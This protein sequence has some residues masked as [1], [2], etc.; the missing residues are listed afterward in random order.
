MA[1]RKGD[2][3][4]YMDSQDNSLR[5]GSCET[6][7]APFHEANRRAV[8][9]LPHATRYRIGPTTRVPLSSVTPACELL[10]LA[11][12]PHSFLIGLRPF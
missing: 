10:F 2:L 6:Q 4:F 8:P 9:V 12:Q 1:K 3:A 11:P 5:E 7:R